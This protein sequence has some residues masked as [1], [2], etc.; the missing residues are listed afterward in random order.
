MA[1]ENR[2][3]I[4]TMPPELF[5]E[6]CKN[7]SPIDLVSLSQ[8]N[9]RFRGFLC[10]F[11]SS[12]SEAIWRA[13]RLIMLPDLQ[14]PPPPNMNE[15]SYVQLANLENGCQFCKEK[16]R[17]HVKV[18]WEFQVRSCEPC[19]N[20]RTISEAELKVK[21]AYSEKL[22]RTMSYM[23]IPRLF[24]SAS[25]R[26]YWLPGID[27]DA[28]EYM[29]IQDKN[30]RLLWTLRRELNRTDI[31]IDVGNRACEEA[32]K[33]KMANVIIASRDRIVYFRQRFQHEVGELITE[34]EMKYRLEK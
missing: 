15:R 9:R 4:V 18:Y 23:G 27:D 2:A 12:S 33:E 16:N 13:S 20:E 25:G 31:M 6:T 29:A 3:S 1:D 10:T 34:L 22:L 24:D 5:V 28:A 7:L 19:I 21:W 14:L 32:K 30:R 26:R 8:V 11:D 17:Q